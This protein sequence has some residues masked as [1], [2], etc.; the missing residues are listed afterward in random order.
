MTKMTR[1]YK[2]AGATIVESAQARSTDS[3]A[4]R[5]EPPEDADSDLPIE[6]SWDTP[7]KVLKAIPPKGNEIPFA[8]IQFSV[9]RERIRHIEAKALCKLRHPHRSKI[10]RSF[11]DNDVDHRQSNFAGYSLLMRAQT[12]FNSGEAATVHEIMKGQPPG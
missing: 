8:Y 2:G 1:R 12:S 3:A 9:S 4:I 7:V 6:A 11:I 10:L 5:E